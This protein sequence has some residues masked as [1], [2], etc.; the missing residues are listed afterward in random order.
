MTQPLLLVLDTATR[1]PMVALAGDDGTLIVRRTWESR[2]RHGEQLLSELD[3][4]FAEAAAG[5]RDVA[6][7]V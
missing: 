2:H 6:G 4:L 5:P 7:I 3:G 1:Q